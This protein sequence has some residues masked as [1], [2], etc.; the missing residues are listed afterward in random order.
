[1][2]LIYGL[3]HSIVRLSQFKFKGG[4]LFT[5]RRIGSIFF[6]KNEQR[7]QPVISFLSIVSVPWCSVAGRT[8]E[9]GKRDN[10][11]EIESPAELTSAVGRVTS[12]VQGFF[13]VGFTCVHFPLIHASLFSDSH[14]AVSIGLLPSRGRVGLR[15]PTK[16][17]GRCHREEDVP[18]P[19]RVN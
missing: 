19:G 11:G 4:R 2:S 17:R 16:P 15:V 14:T 13:A 12:K 5:N 9:E 1:M 8:R 7:H 6:F 18:Q 3:I 10:W